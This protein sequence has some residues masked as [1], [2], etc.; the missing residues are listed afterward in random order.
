MSEQE[1]DTDREVAGITYK[2]MHCYGDDREMAK[3]EAYFQRIGGK[4]WARPMKVQ[5]GD[6][7]GQWAC[8]VSYANKG[9]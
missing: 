4:K 7:K 1:Y 5:G 8:Y 2:M 9:D 3:I 6:F